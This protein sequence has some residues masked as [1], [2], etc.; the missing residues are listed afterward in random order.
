MTVEPVWACSPW[1]TN[2]YLLARPV[3][4][5]QADRD[6]FALHASALLDV[7][8]GAIG[9][10]GALVVAPAA[11]GVQG[12]ADRDSGGVRGGQRCSRSSLPVYTEV[13][14]MDGLKRQP[15]SLNQLTTAMLNRGCPSG[16]AAPLLHEP[17]GRVGRRQHAVR[18]VV[19]A[20]RRLRIHVRAHHH[21]R[22]AG[23][24]FERPNWLPARSNFTVKPLA[25]SRP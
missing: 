17:E 9:G 22:R 14:I 21:V 2:S 23:H 5:H 1:T 25:S 18:A 16:P 15:S 10:L 4:V 7:D 8:F 6:A 20:G 11:D 24:R 13:P 19:A 3:G 12:L